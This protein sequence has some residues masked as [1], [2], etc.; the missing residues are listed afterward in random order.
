MSSGTDIL[1]SFPVNEQ[2]GQLYTYRVSQ[3]EVILQTRESTVQMIRV[4]VGIQPVA[5]GMYK[6][7]AKN[8]D[9]TN[10]HTVSVEPTG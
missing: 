6:C 1:P 2:A 9:K 3:S 4:A 8:V 5:G 10:N 7:V